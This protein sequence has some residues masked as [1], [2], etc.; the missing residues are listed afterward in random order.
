MPAG[1]VLADYRPGG[2]VATSGVAYRAIPASACRAGV[3]TPAAGEQLT[4]TVYVPCAVQITG[5]SIAATI[6]ADGP[7]RI[8]GSGTR[9]GPAT[10]G[11]PAIVTAAAGTDAVLITG[12]NV[13]V[14][15]AVR[16]AA[17]P[18][19]IAGTAAVLE[20]G[21]VATNMTLTGA[22]TAARMTARCL[23]P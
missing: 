7:V 15:G 20:C 8:A 4:G 3:W 5:G 10:A 12:A 17:G 2:P 11:A 6:A 21:V 18:V 14:S 23:A 22:N 13:A 19:R 1:P 16:A 9:V